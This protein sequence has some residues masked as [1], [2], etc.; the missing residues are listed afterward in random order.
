MN[1]WQPNVEYVLD[2]SY[3]FV[4]VIT[5]KFLLQEVGGGSSAGGCCEEDYQG[6]IAM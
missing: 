2:V 3:K 4:L 1:F 6:L 5:D